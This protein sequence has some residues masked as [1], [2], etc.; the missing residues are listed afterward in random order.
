MEE[1]TK[2]PY[3]FI[4]LSAESLWLVTLVVFLVTRRVCNFYFQA[5]NSC[6]HGEVS[7]EAMLEKGESRPPTCTAAV[8]VAPPHS[9]SSISRCLQNTPETLRRKKWVLLFVNRLEDATENLL[10]AR[11]SIKGLQ[12]SSLMHV[13]PPA[14][15]EPESPVR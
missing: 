10:R 2:H 11:R 4:L 8:V 5:M 3:F 1:E 9:F 12:R 14:A 6:E 13:S 7:E 15:R